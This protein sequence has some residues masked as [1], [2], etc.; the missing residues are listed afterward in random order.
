M[1][2]ISDSICKEN[3]NMYFIFKIL[4]ENNAVYEIIWKNT[5]VLGG[6]QTTIQYGSCAL[7][8]G[9][10]RLQTHT[11]GLCNAYCLFNAAMFARTR[12][13]VT[14]CVHCLSCQQTVMWGE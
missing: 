12:L 8:A 10:L 14:L 6:T 5:V 3:Q 4:F 7:H 9:Y 11:V 1:R 13:Q 2:N